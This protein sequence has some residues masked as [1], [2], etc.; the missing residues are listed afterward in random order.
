MVRSIASGLAFLHS[1]ITGTRNKPAIA[2]RDLKS[3]NI[4]VKID[5]SCC[6]ADLGLAVRYDATSGTIDIPNNN[7]VGTKRYLAPEVLDNS[8]NLN[9]FDNYRRADIYSMGLVM[10]EICRGTNVGGLYSSYEV[11]YN[12]MV[13]A[14]PSIEDM[15]KCVCDE[16]KRP[17]IPNRWSESQVLRE[18]A[19]L[20]REC[21]AS[22]PDA[23]LTALRVKKSVDALTATFSS[24]GTKII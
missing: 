5:G 18:M 7:K 22:R 14:D 16:N 4:L 19:R 6:I 12:D 17:T 2:H 21:W 10:W 15:R 20:M 13:P 11:P 24:G 8:M 9:Q 1:E 3:K 23:R